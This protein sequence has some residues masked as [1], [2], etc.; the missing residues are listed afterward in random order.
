M[1]IDPD[2]P[3]FL[4]ISV[5]VA[6]LAVHH[7]LPELSLISLIISEHNHSKSFLNA[8]DKLTLV[9]GSPP[10]RES[11][12]P[13][14]FPVRKAPD[15]NVAIVV[16]KHA[17]ALHFALHPL[18]VVETPVGEAVLAL[19]RFDAHFEKAVELGA[20]LPLLFALAVAVARLPEAV[21]DHF[22]RHE[23]A[24]PVEEVLQEV[25]IVFVSVRVGR[26]AEAILL[27][28]RVLA[29]VRGAVFVLN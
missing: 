24:A 8:F 18:A 1:A 4:V 16:P 20:V 15:V 22:S 13:I 7:V 17:H 12:S 27:V 3:G 21:V 9:D 10:R 23:L 6:P 5:I 19:A 26:D 11:P 25:A 28:V 29:F 2:A 14:S